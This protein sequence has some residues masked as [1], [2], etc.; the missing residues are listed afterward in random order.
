MESE[1]MVSQ[2]LPA[3][4]ERSS[5]LLVP[6]MDLNTA[7]LRMR[8]FQ[9]FISGYLEES[10]DGG[11]TGDYGVIAGTKKKTLLKSGADKL[12]E[13]YGL[14]DEYVLTSTVDWEKGLFDYEVKC[15]LKSRRDDSVVGTGLGCCSSY[16]SKYR[17][18]DSQRKC[19]QCGMEALIKGK[20]FNNTGLPQPWVCFTKKGGCNAKFAPGDKAVE[21]QTIG[22]VENPDI[23]DIKNTVMKMAKK[24]AKI[25]ATIGATRSSGILTQDLEDLPP[26]APAARPIE[27]TEKP[28]PISGPGKGSP[29]SEVKGA[30]E[31]KAADVFSQREPGDE[32]PE[33][34][35]EP[36][37]RRGPIDLAHQRAIH[38]AF[39]DAIRNEG[40]K[41]GADAFLQDWLKRQG[42][43]DG[44]DRG[45]TK[46]IR[47][48]QFEATKAAAVAFAAGLPL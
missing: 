30:P 28:I 34:D 24:R 45:T 19:P 18:R 5:V 12:C 29:V 15:I 47:F 8:E 9:D 43:V 40:A 11:A 27:V 31:I 6:V 22:R 3:V 37:P 33:V 2:M 21:S 16:E 44:E 48:E 1:M 32:A 36:A 17:W 42:F 10:T 7:K 26:I 35:T 13:V 41:K 39:R 38:R 23:I 25:D 4:I 46:T 20:D 14:Y